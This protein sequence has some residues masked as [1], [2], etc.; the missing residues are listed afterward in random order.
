MSSAQHGFFCFFCG[1]HC[2]PIAHVQDGRVVMVTPDT[3]SGILS[4]ICPDAKGPV[5]IPAT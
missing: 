5:T 4:D 3:T 2:S 1:K